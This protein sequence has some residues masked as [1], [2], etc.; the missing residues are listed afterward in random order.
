M[1]NKKR[2]AQAGESTP[3]ISADY[4]MDTSYKKPRS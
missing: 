3:L 4:G 2:S 1:G